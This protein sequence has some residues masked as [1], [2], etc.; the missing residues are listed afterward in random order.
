M[1]A[2]LR[3]SIA[4]VI[5]EL[6]VNMTLSRSMSD[7]DA[8]PPRLLVVWSWVACV[9]P[10][11]CIREHMNPEALLIVG[12]WPTWILHRCW[13][14]PGV[15][16]FAPVLVWS[17]CRCSFTDRLDNV[18]DFSKCILSCLPGAMSFAPFLASSVVNV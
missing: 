15:E 17:A 5:D 6:F 1:A 4:L 13:V 18:S 14:D 10:I 8:V 2:N 11:L 9:N 7:D 3:C 12:A 16:L